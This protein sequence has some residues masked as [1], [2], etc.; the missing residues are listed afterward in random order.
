MAR[1]LDNKNTLM[2]RLKMLKKQRGLINE[3]IDIDKV[4][5]GKG[6]VLDIYKKALDNINS[7]IL[8]LMIIMKEEM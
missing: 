8:D 3:L 5:Y 1:V 7:E 4:L 2:V 6:E